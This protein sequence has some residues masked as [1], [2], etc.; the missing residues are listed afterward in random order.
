MALILGSSSPRRKRLL[1]EEGIDFEA[2]APE[3]DEEKFNYGEMPERVKRISKK[4]AE[5]IID[6]LEE[7]R[8]VLTADTMIEF[9]GKALGK[10]GSKKK[11]EERLRE[12]LG[13][14]CNAYTG[15]TVYR[16]GEIDTGVEKATIKFREASEEEIR[17]Y[18]ES[19]PVENMAGGFNINRGKPGEKFVEDIEGYRSTVVGLPVEVILPLL[20]E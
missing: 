20:E 7:E 5:E 6:N 4:K 2:R 9:R 1:E 17:D 13:N 8:I 15:Y 14:S 18:V 12:I 3:I 10:P 19:E 11:A 16:K